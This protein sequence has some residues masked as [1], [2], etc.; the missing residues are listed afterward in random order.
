MSGRAFTLIEVLIAFAILLLASIAIYS[1]L[2]VGIRATRQSGRLTEA[3]NFGRHIVELIRVRNLPFS[4]RSL[5]P[6]RDSGLNDFPK[7][8]R[9]LDAAPFGNS[10]FS[11]LPD[12]SNFTRNITMS[13]LSKDKNS[14][15]SQII[16]LKVTVY[17]SEK[18]FERKAELFTLHRQP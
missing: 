15:D 18:R 10:D 7:D 12:T 1:M 2:S 13:R 14:F 11:G 16:K 3:V 6:A 17:W 5:P 4:Q 9:P 8:R